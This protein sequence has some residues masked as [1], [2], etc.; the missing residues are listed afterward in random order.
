MCRQTAHHLYEYSVEYCPLFKPYLISRHLG[1][2]AN[3]RSVVYANYKSD[4]GNIEQSIHIIEKCFK[5][6]LVIDTNTYVSSSKNKQS[7]FNMPES[8]TSLFYISY[9][10]NVIA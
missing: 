8:D 1:N 5:S 7:A 10:S 3:F 2:V 9:T 6:E 4:N